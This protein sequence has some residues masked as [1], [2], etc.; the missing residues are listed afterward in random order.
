MARIYKKLKKYDRR[1]IEKMFKQGLKAQ[2]IAD[3]LGLDV[4]PVSSEITRNHPPHR[5]DERD[6]SEITRN[7]PPHRSDESDDSDD[8]EL[9]YTIPGDG[10]DY[11]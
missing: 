6:D 2:E 10:G 11:F 1:R 3:K 4:K 5:S 9:Y 7:H 8:D